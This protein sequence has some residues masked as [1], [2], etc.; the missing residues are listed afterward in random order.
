MLFVHVQG[1]LLVI[2]IQ[3][4]GQMLQFP[5]CGSSYYN[6]KNKCHTFPCAQSMKNKVHTSLVSLSVQAYSK[7]SSATYFLYVHT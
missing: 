2:F 1:R 5:V 3:T 7:A 6:F 4:Q